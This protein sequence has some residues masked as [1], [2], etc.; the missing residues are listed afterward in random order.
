VIAKS[1]GI[2]NK[3]SQVDQSSS[4]CRTCADTTL[5]AVGVP[6]KT[7]TSNV[8]CVFD[9]LPDSLSHDPQSVAHQFL[10]D[11]SDIL[12]KSKFELGRTDLLHHIIDTEENRH[13]LR[14]HPL[15][16]LK[17]SDDHGNEMLEHNII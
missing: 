16:H 4:S 13:L 1:N 5:E 12:S 14:R 17:I 9:N 11:Y 2:N 3:G 10:Q 15:A 7:K 6:T 8:Q